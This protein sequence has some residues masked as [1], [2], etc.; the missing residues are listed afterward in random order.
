M[1]PKNT[2]SELGRDTTCKTVNAVHSSTLE[3][4]VT[5]K[6]KNAYAHAE[7]PIASMTNAQ[8]SS[9]GLFG[10]TE[11][12]FPEQSAPMATTQPS[13]RVP[14]IPLTNWGGF[15]PPG[16]GKTTSTVNDEYV[17]P[18]RGKFSGAPT[19]EKASEGGHYKT[20]THQRRV[21]PTNS[22]TLGR[23]REPQG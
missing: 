13:A 9:D 6:T 4:Q 12:P 18:F 17:Q 3:H 10:S 11:G 21:R 23:H 7:K 15:N 8:P 16:R 1:E 5:H 22:Q 20:R 2:T 14:P 19:Q